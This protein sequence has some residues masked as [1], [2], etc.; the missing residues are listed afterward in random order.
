MRTWRGEP[1]G[2]VPGGDLD[3]KVIWGRVLA[4]G[5]VEEGGG[6]RGGNIT[7]ITSSITMETSPLV[8]ALLSHFVS[9]SSLMFFFRFQRL[10]LLSFCRKYKSGHL[11]NPRNTE[12]F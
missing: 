10:I 4:G 6:S 8:Q 1:L 9:H 2:P 3:A 11:K 7:L 5:D 12:K